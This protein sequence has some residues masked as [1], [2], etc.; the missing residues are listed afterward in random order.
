MVIQL[1]SFRSSLLLQICSSQPAEEQGEGSRSLEQRCWWVTDRSFWFPG[2]C[3][4][5]V[6]GAEG[7]CVRACVRVSVCLRSVS[8]MES[9][10]QHREAR[11]LKKKQ[12]KTNKQPESTPVKRHHLLEH[13]RHARAWVG[14]IVLLLT[15]AFSSSAAV[16]NTHNPPT[17]AWLPPACPCVRERPRLF[18]RGSGGRQEPQ[19]MSPD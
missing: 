19:K 17:D 8:V 11:H 1:T 18:Q 4:I 12:Q 14:G 16:R 7:V 10:H 13:T 6:L 9:C 2:C 5:C 15:C 3:R